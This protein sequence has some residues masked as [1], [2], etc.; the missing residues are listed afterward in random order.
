MRLETKRLIIAS[1]SPR[2]KKCGFALRPVCLTWEH[3]GNDTL[4]WAQEVP[5][6]CTRGALLE[7][8]LAKMPISWR[9]E[10]HCPRNDPHGRA[11]LP[12]KRAADPFCLTFSGRNSPPRGE[13][14]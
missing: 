14:E 1:R 13:Y 4:L 2:L 11:H 6:A 3:R 5:G 7:E 8:A 12:R 10:T 9:G